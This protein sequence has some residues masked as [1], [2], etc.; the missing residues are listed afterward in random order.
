MF[1]LAACNS[2]SE[3]EQPSADDP[4]LAQES[5]V[6]GLAMSLQTTCALTALG[7]LYC[8]GENRFGEFANGT[9]SPS[10][11]PIPGGG[12]LT[13][14]L[15]AGSM[16]TA[17]MCGRTREGVTYCWGYNVTG[18][19]GDGTTVNRSSPA[20]VA[21]NELFSAI[22]SSNHTCAINAQGTAFCWGSGLGGRLGTGNENTA[23]RPTAVLSPEF[24]GRITTGQQFSCALTRIGEARCWGVG[25]GLGSGSADRSVNIPTAVTG[26]HIFQ[27]ISAGERHVCAV[28]LGGVVYCWGT[29]GSTAPFASAPVRVP[30]TKPIIVVVSG[31]RLSV[32]EASCGLTSDGAAYCWQAA[33][34]QP[35]PGDRRF[36]GLAGGH[37]RFCGH[38][39]GGAI[40]CW[41]LEPNPANTGWLITEPERTVLTPVG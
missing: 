29:L 3:P 23:L 30:T 10:A 33:E 13:F 38:T 25:Q 22:A 21:G 26:G 20:R 24:F 35:V 15:I 28:T 32:G 18:E 27:S 16:G 11:H 8:W 19:L 34:S 14:D 36:A 40:F 31:S 9:T 2:T 5:R 17:Q 7:K 37:G 41:R 1:L 6:I 4:L 39:I 12:T